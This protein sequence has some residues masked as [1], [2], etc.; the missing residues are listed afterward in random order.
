MVQGDG[1]CLMSYRTAR[2]FRII[3]LDK[4]IAGP[5]DQ[6][7]ALGPY[8]VQSEADEVLSP[9]K[10]TLEAMTKRFPALFSE[11][12]VKAGRAGHLGASRQQLRTDALGCQFCH[13]NQRQR[14]EERETWQMQVH[15]RSAA[16]SN[17]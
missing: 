6:R 4:T 5:K 8:S 10:S 2:E 17:Y 1:E 13:R 11:K 3:R 16:V 12:L 14:R 7:T 9:D 15:I